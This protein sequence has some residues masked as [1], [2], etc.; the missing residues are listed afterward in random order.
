MFMHSAYARD[1]EKS[2]K[3]VLPCDTPQHHQFDFWLGDW[4]VYDMA[5][6]K[7]V[8]FDHVEKQLNGCAVIQR[9]TWLSD[10]FRRPELGYR[11]S[12]MSVNVVRDGHWSTLWI[13]N[14]YGNGLIVEGG[15]QKDSMVMTTQAPRNGTYTRGVW[16]PN[17]DGSVRNMGYLSR[18]GKTA[19]TPY[20]DY[21][22]RP[23]R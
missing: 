20:F 8:A 21:L 7:L 13:D 12:G 18:D 6:S 9:M 10:Q 2:P 17:P 15:I 22:Y 16:T 14:T 11:L 23:N 5:T 19:W 1:F 4:L 3:A